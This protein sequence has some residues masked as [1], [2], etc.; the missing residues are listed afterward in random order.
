MNKFWLMN[1]TKACELII[2]ARNMTLEFQ[3][4]FKSK[5]ILG[6]HTSKNK[7]PWFTNELKLIK[8]E[9]KNL[10]KNIQNNCKQDLFLEKKELKKKFRRI[11][12]QNLFIIES[13][14]LSKFEIHSREQ[15]KTKFW[16]FINKSKKKRSNE[17]EIN[18][19]QNILFDH[20]KNFFQDN[21][22]L[23]EE[24]MNIKEKVDSNFKNF[25]K[26]DNPVLFKIIDLKD[27]LKD[28]KNSNVKG[29]D[30]I[31]YNLIKNI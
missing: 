19:S 20:Y 18:I 4:F 26:M 8:E 13:K 31:S 14:E 9:I 6:K 11:Q 22:I 25:V 30:K 23:S 5:P 1:F 28:L 10:N 3:N 29:Y 27:I 16:K 7:T 17:N 15:N 12:R 21:L 24:Q 2:K